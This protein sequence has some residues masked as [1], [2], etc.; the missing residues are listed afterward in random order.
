[1]DA[2]RAIRENLDKRISLVK[3]KSTK[4][5]KF[6]ANYN[7]RLTQDFEVPQWI[8]ESCKEQPQV[9]VTEF[10]LGKRKRNEVTY[11]D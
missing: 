3:S 4:D 2:D 8:Q 10:G 11:K 9:D 6:S 1:M 5:K 7:Y